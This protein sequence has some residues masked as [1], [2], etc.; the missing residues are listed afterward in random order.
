MF[1]DPHFITFDGNPKPVLQNTPS[2]NSFWAVHSPNIK[3]QGYATGNGNWIQGVAV[4]G[5]FMGAHKLRAWR[6]GSSGIKVDFDGKAQ[7][8]SQGSSYKDLNGK[9]ELHRNMGKDF[10]P[11]EEEL[12]KIFGIAAGSKNWYQLD[13]ALRSW[14]EKRDVFRLK[15]PYKVEIWLVSSSLPGAGAAEIIIK[16]PPQAQQGGWCGNAN[17]KKEDDQNVEW[18]SALDPNDDEFGGMM[19]MSQTEQNDT[20]ATPCAGEALS[21]SLDACAHLLDSSMREACIV[22]ACVT[23]EVELA[24]TSADDVAIMKGILSSGNKECVKK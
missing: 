14:K 20:A 7:L 11:S 5:P 21:M 4:H 10:I 23:K 6:S 13:Q 17:G 1:G 18:L 19:S 16:M 3:I 24:A 9:V 2:M 8:T 15:L 12:R 22:D